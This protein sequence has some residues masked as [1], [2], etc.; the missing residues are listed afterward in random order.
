M[1]PVI[2]DINRT[3]TGQSPNPQRRIRTQKVANLRDIVCHGLRWFATVCDG[4]Q[5]FAVVCVIWITWPDLNKTTHGSNCQYKCCSSAVR[6]PNLHSHDYTVGYHYK[7][8]K[9][10]LKEDERVEIITLCLCFQGQGGASFLKKEKHRA[11]I[12]LP[13]VTSNTWLQWKKFFKVKISK[14]VARRRCPRMWQDFSEWL[15]Q[16]ASL[17]GVPQRSWTWPH[18]QTPSTKN[19]RWLNWLRKDAKNSQNSLKLVI[20]WPSMIPDKK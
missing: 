15:I 7:L 4:L 9:I 14:W 2:P 13:F 16:T 12:L 6:D 1:P 11:M 18:N 5:W 8:V 3:Q 20:N 10:C 17:N 19:W